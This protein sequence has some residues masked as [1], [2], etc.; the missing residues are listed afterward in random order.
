MKLRGINV[1]VFDAQALQIGLG[2]GA[3]RRDLDPACGDV[4]DLSAVTFHDSEHAGQFPEER[5]LGDLK[6]IVWAALED[7]IRV[8]ATLERPLTRVA[9]VTVNRRLGMVWIAAAWT[10][11]RLARTD[12]CQN[13]QPLCS[14]AGPPHRQATGPEHFLSSLPRGSVLLAPLGK[15]SRQKGA[16]RTRLGR[17]KLL[18]KAAQPNVLRLN[19]FPS[20]TPARQGN[21]LPAFRMPLVPLGFVERADDDDPVGKL[22]RHPAVCKRFDFPEGRERA[23]RAIDLQS[24]VAQAM[25]GLEAMQSKSAPLRLD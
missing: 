22:D 19:V 9:D 14:S 21:E 10:V 15:V 2:A 13:R 7:A 1:M 3:F 12:G 6:D 20:R 23:L 11:P 25:G 4:F 17:D 5:I 16:Q 8:V 18:I 24:Q